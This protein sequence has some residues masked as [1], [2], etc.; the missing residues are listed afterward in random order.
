MRSIKTLYEFEL[1]SCQEWTVRVRK[2]GHGSAYC[3]SR[4]FRMHF[5]FVYCNRRN[6]CTRFN[7]VYFVLLAE[8]TKI[9]SIR[10]PCTYTSVCDTAFKVRKFIAYENS[11]TLE[12]EIFTRT[13]ISAITVF[14]TRRLPYENK[15]ILKFQSHCKVTNFRTFEGLRRKWR[16]NS[17]ASK[18]KEIFIRY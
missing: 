9:S 4:I 12:Y 15:S 18:Q 1:W 10:K 16:W 6:F 8:S 7:F 13:K 2:G 11:P 5:I 14:R 17:M 3:K